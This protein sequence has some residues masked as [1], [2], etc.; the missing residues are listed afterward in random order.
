MPK[1]K[2]VPEKATATDENEVQDNKREREMRD[3]FRLVRPHN[4]SR[5]SAD[6][7]LEI[8]HHAIEFE[9]KSSTDKRRS[10]STARDVSH[11][12]IA[13][14]R[15]RHWLFGFYTPGGH[16]LEYCLYGP[17]GAMKEWIDKMEGYIA[18]DYT[19]ASRASDLLGDVDLHAVLGRKVK[20]TLDDAKRLH[21]RQWNQE[22]YE[23]HMD[24][25]DGYSSDRMLEILKLRCRYLL[26]RGATLNNP[27]I[28]GTYFKTWQRIT[29]NH[30]TVLR[31]LVALELPRTKK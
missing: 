16:K 21:K 18:P 24:C 30:A 29:S 11:D 12:H 9:L 14:W 31:N 15:T 2:T 27:H 20:Y 5:I 3:L 22:Q 25:K 1:A 8:G 23:S 13:K 10:V 19:L 7:V 28:P 6:A 26:E 17:P 4:A